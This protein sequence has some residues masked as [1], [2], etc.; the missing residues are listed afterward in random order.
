MKLLS[1][2]ILCGA[3]LCVVGCGKK[4]R[5]CS[6]PQECNFVHEREESTVVFQD[7]DEGEIEVM[8]QK[9]RVSGVHQHTVN[10]E[11]D[12]VK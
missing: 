6:A 3:L 4:Q 8:H 10:S 5:S 9:V 1:Q 7:T 12:M 2:A 11:E